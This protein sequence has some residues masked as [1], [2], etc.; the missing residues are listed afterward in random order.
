MR[1]LVL[2]TTIS[3]K[4][5]E[6]ENEVFKTLREV[7]RG[8]FDRA[9]NLNGDSKL[10]LQHTG[11]IWKFTNF[12]EDFIETCIDIDKDEEDEKQE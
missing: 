7:S 11:M 6:K 4:N 5:Y 12:G 9:F 10:L 2:L 1:D 3:L 8:H